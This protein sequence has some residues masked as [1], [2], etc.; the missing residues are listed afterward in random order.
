[1]PKKKYRVDLSLAERKTFEQLLRRG[2]AGT[3]KLSRARMLLKA[4]EGLSDAKMAATRPV[5][6]WLTAKVVARGLA[7]SKA[8]ETVRLEVVQQRAPRAWPP[9]RTGRTSPRARCSHTAP[10]QL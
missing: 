10:E 6:R 8:Y 7:E 9:W 4:D 1:M 2:K 3:R 5:G